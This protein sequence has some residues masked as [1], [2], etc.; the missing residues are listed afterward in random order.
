MYPG[1][2][3]LM[4]FGTS[5]VNQDKFLVYLEPHMFLKAYT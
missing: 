1:H 2:S 3:D 4:V 5:D